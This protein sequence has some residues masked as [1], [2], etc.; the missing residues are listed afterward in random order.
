MQQHSLLHGCRV[1]G[2][3]DALNGSVVLGVRVAGVF[4]QK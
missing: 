1:A 2:S 3:G 4:R